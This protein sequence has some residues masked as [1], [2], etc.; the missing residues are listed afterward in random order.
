MSSSVLLYDT[1]LRDGAQRQ[2]ISFSVADKLRITKLLAD[3]GIDY[4]EGGWPSSNPKDAEY[5]RRARELDLGATIVCAFGATRRMNNSADHDA[6]LIGLLEAQTPVVTIVGKASRLHVEQILRASKQD[7]LRAIEDSVR[8][9]KRE[10]REVV[11]DAEHFFD[12][13]AED[14]EY[15]LACL[16]AAESA[17]ADWLVLCDT[18]GGSLPETIF[19]VIEAVT[20]KVKTAIGIHAHNDC[21]LAVANSLAAVRAGAR[22]I[23]GTINGIGERCGNANLVSL[24]PNLALKMRQAVRAAEKLQELTQ[25]SRQVSE[26]ANLAPNNFAAYVGHNAF[27]HKG[28]LHAA[29]VQRMTASYEHIDPAL[30]GNGREILVSE[31]AGRG[32]IRLRAEQ[33]GLDIGEAEQIVTNEIKQAEARGLSLEAADGSFELIV[34]RQ[35]PNYRPPFSVRDLMVQSLRRTGEHQKSLATA[36][37]QVDG[38][39]TLTAAEANGPVAAIDLAL[40]QALNPF[41]PCIEDIRLSDYKVRILD[42]EQATAATT[43]VWI[44]AT[45]GEQSWCTVGCSENII[46]ASAE[47]LLASL[48][49]FIL[50]L[51]E[52]GANY[53]R[54]NAA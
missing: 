3:F 17:G 23:Q 46:E 15:A 31:L 36:K 42:P 53:G 16:Q 19:T 7:N 49:L 18:N 41:Y 43:R 14:G 39:E 51:Q 33:L 20:R 47:A 48:E 1:T 25:V 11:F 6:Q 5:F 24:L 30:V 4:I 32:N 10:G 54:I 37:V 52:K 22:Q 13:F 8:L 45:V 40:R 29:A 28:G 9:L 12:G 35:A 26:I 50:R 44:E 38:V 27:A 34:R 2:G 21:E